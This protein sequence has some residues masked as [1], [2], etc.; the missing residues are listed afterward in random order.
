[1]KKTLTITAALV[2]LVAVAATATLFT[3]SAFAGSHQTCGKV[4]PAE[5]RTAGDPALAKKIERLARCEP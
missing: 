1:M 4:K 3:L 5:L 2:V